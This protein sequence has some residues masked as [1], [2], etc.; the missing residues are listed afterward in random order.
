M[1]W[2]LAI[3]IYLTIGA[4]LI[5][6]A[7]HDEPIQTPPLTFLFLTIFW[8]FIFIIAAINY[9]NGEDDEDSD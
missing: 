6:Y 5:A 3:A 1:Y 7:L 2:V 4:G 8:G 9:Y